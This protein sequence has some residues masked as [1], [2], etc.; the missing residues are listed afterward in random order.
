MRLPPNRVEVELKQ[1]LAIHLVRER[2]CTLAQGARLAEMNRLEFERLLGER[3][4]PWPGT[5]DDVRRAPEAL[6]LR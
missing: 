2:I 6:D 5:L 3:H 4:V 1:E